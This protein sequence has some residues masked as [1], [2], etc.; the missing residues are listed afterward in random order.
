MTLG[1]GRVGRQG[2]GLLCHPLPWNLV[3]GGPI[4]CGAGASWPGGDWGEGRA[5][6]NGGEPGAEEGLQDGG[7]MEWKGAVLG[8]YKG[9]W[10]P[11]LPAPRLLSSVTV[12]ASSSLANR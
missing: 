6:G 10:K 12:F 5:S 9:P 2:H 11:S 1:T 3:G 7:G 4:W 8:L